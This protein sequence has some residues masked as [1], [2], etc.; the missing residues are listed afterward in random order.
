MYDDSSNILKNLKLII[1]YINYI[2]REI[3]IFK[4]HLKA[5]KKLGG[6]IF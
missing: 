2:V 3:H 5:S 6:F 4:M 1:V